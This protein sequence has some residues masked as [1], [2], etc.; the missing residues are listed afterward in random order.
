MSSRQRVVETGRERQ[1]GHFIA[2]S[3]AYLMLETCTTHASRK[4]G[5]AEALPM[6]VCAVDSNYS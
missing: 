6:L 4:A 1:R 5:G 2:E 3:L